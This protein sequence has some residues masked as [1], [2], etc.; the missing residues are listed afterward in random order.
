MSVFSVRGFKFTDLV[1]PWH[2]EWSMNSS[3]DKSVETN[4][5][6]ASPF[7]AG[8]QLESVQ[9]SITAEIGARNLFRFHLGRSTAKRTEVR[10]P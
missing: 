6:P 3:A 1:T 5:C 7:R 2:K 9:R 8:Q 4:R 10:A